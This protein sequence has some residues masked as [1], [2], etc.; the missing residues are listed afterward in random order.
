M[1]IVGEVLSQ[2][3]DSRYKVLV[4]FEDVLL[5]IVPLRETAKDGDVRFVGNDP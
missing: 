2:E 3:D 5:R 1:L 4:S